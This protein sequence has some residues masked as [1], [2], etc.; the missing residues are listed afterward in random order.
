MTRPFHFASGEYRL[1]RVAIDGSCDCGTGDREIWVA[2]KLRG[3]NE[4][5]TFIHEGLHAEF[6]DMPEAEVQAAGEHLRDFLWG[7]GYRKNKYKRGKTRT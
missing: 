5:E 3:R 2:P 4:L 7:V 6:P 1:S